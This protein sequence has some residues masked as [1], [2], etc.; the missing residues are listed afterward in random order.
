MRGVCVCVVEVTQN[1]VLDIGTMEEQYGSIWKW[2]DLRTIQL[3]RQKG[4]PWGVQRETE[5]EL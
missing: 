5:I 3:L 4:V 2:Q 1:L